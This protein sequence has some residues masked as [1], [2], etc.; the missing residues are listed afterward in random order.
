MKSKI[1]KMLLVACMCAI[2]FIGNA[3]TVIQMEEYGGVYRIPCKVNGAKMKLIFDTG[4]DKVC[5]SLSMADYLYDNDYIT[6]EDIIGSGSSTVADGS[7]VNHIKINIKDI[8]IQGIHLKNVEAVVMDGQDAPLLLGQ[9]AIKKLGK[10]SISGNKLIIETDIISSKTK[11]ILLSKTETDQLLKDA[12]NAF[13]KDL[14]Y[15]AE[16]KYHILYEAGKLNSHRILKYITSMNRIG[17][18]DDALGLCLSLQKKFEQN[19]ST[20]KADLYKHIGFLYARKGEKDSSI[21]YIEKARYYAKQW[22]ELQY[23]TTIYLAS[24]Y[25][26]NDKLPDAIFLL[27][28][29]ID[30]YLNYKGWKSTDCWEKSKRDDL[31][32]RLYGELARLYYFDDEKY[33]VIS[34]AWGNDNSI[35]E[36]E[37]RGLNYSS[38]R[39]IYKYSY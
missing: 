8:E 5:L 27:E 28:D 4:A 1:R 38:N 32:G 10:Y 23:T 17:K 11:A 29:Y 33:Y 3:Q 24:V 19:Y 21:L 7:I 9:S 37:N 31:L 36:C 14:M 26:L 18:V 35:E 34:A 6:N 16:E 2:Y 20:E 30:K 15:V 39:N 22:S 12:D 13:D 25:F